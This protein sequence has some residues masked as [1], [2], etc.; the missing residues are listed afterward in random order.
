M[1]KWGSPT[2]GWI[3]A[4]RAAKG[5]GLAG[6]LAKETTLRT[7]AFA[8]CSAL[9]LA[10]PPAPA[11]SEKSVVVKKALAQSVR[12]EVQAGRK[13]AATASGVVVGSAEG[14]SFILTNAHVVAPALDDGG[15]LVVIVERP[16]LLRLPARLVANGSVPDEDLALLAVERSLPAAAL[17]GNDEVTMGDD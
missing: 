6:P 15:K 3:E 10:A 11:K 17:A 9:V 16:R 5:P 14:T 8:L 1:R 13:V 2:R 12:I 7:L 4:A